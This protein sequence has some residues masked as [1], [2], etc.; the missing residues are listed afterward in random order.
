MR[1]CFPSC[2]FVPFVPSCS[3]S[4]REGVSV[5][6]PSIDIRN[7][8]ERVKG[9]EWIAPNGIINQ[10]KLRESNIARSAMDR[11]CIAAN[12]VEPLGA[13]PA[14]GLWVARAHDTRTGRTFEIRSTVL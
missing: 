14:D 2:F 1:R 4:P 5:H 3:L 7:V 9:T 8:E 12:Y 6:A 10:M 11:G 13:K